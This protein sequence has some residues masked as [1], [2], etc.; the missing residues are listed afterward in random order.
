M[1]LFVSVTCEIVPDMEMLVSACNAEF[2][3]GYEDTNNYDVGW[4]PFDKHAHRSTRPT[5]PWIYGSAWDTGT[6]PVSGM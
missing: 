5:Q 6:V 4:K 1:M 3:P 2:S